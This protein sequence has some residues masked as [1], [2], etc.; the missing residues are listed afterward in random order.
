MMAASELHS[1]FLCVFCVFLCFSNH[2]T[3][4]SG[5]NSV[6]SFSRVEL[7]NIRESSLGIF[8]QSFIDSSFTERNRT[9]LWDTA[10]KASEGNAC[11]RAG[12]APP[13]RTWHSCLQSNWQM[14]AL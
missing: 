9:T 11:W 12:K 5:H 2:S 13:K 14:S 10:P 4:V 3:V 1:L 6:V 8:S 7:L